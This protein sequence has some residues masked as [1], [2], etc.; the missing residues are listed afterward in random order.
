MGIDTTDGVELNLQARMDLSIVT[1][2]PHPLQSSFT[3][4]IAVRG[5]CPKFDNQAIAGNGGFFK[6]R[7]I[8]LATKYMPIVNQLVE[9]GVIEQT[10]AT[11]CSPLFLIP[12]A[13]GTPRV[14]S[15][16]SNVSKNFIK[17]PFK[18]KTI[19]MIAPMLAGARKATK[20]DLKSAFYSIPLA[21]SR[22]R[23]FGFATASNKYRY[24]TL[25]M[26]AGFSPYALQNIVL[27]ICAK[28]IK[29]ANYSV[30]LDDVIIFHANEHIIFQDTKPD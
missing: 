6:N 19:P 7:F 4:K 16:F 26:G 18:L 14:I 11:F 25:P 5:F 3:R 8:R 22:R 23:F 9:G 10:D 27:D 17:Y 12:K 20:I 15:D 30:Y 13:D 21:Q 24:K 2:K 29:S 28:W 1:L